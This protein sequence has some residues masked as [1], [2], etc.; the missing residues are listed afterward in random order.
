M[1]CEFKKR[2]N[3]S[4]RIVVCTNGCG[5]KVKTRLAQLP[6]GVEQKNTF[7]RTRRPLFRPFNMAPVDSRLFRFSDFSSGCRIISE[8]GLGLTPTGYYPCAISGGID[9]VFKLNLGKKRLPLPDDDML[10]Q[11]RKFCPLCG[12][13]GFRWPTRKTK[14]SSSWIHAYRLSGN[15]AAG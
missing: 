11:L 12:H 14:M 10:D 3:P 2:N 9:R 1:L 13:F 6:Q 15:M 5:E 8:C 4:M 7:K